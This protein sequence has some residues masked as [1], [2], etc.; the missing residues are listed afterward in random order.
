[1]GAK[2]LSDLLEGIYRINSQAV[3]PSH[4]HGSQIGWEHFAHQ[5]FVLRID[6]HSLIEMAHVLHWVRSPVVD[7]EC[8]L[9]ETPRKSCPS[10]PMCEGRL[11]NLVQGF[12]HR[13][14]S[15]SSVSWALASTFTVMLLFI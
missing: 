6:S 14:I 15:H 11:G 7:G 13:I 4:H 9:M 3:E 1:M 2:C 8:W 12:A 5:G 10:Y